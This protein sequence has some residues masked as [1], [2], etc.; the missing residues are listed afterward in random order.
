MKQDMKICL[1][2]YKI[3]YSVVFMVLLSLVRGVSTVNEIGVALDANTALLAIVFCAET[4]VMDKRGGRWEIFALFPE[5]NKVKAVRRRLMIQNV[6]LYVIACIGFFFYF[7]QKPMYM[8]G[9]S[10]IYEYAM[11]VFAVVC[12]IFFWSTLAMSISNIFGT[13]WTG[14]G[15]CV[16]L[17]MTVNSTFGEAALGK[18]NIF[19]YGLQSADAADSISWIWGKILGMLLALI[20]A[21]MIPYI[22]K[23]RGMKR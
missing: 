21:G 13:Q 15:V 1:P 19:A 9:D 16:I 5:K 8:E 18:F 6:Y 17:W 10:L 7:W 14:I 23:K 2:V 11:Y 12:T 3:I 22:L 4:H 20:M